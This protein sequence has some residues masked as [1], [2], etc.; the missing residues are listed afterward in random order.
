MSHFTSTSNFA[1]AKLRMFTSQ[2]LHS[3]ERDVPSE[4]IEENRAIPAMVKQPLQDRVHVKVQAE[5]KCWFL[6]RIKV[7]SSQRKPNEMS[8]CFLAGFTV[9]Q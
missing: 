1:I 2:S 5:Q 7:T 6:P 9:L 4:S 8:N 3:Q